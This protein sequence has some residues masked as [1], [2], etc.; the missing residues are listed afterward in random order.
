MASIPDQVQHDLNIIDLKFYDFFMSKSK[1]V[2]KESGRVKYGSLPKPW[3]KIFDLT[4]EYTEALWRVNQYTAFPAEKNVL[5]ER[6]RGAL[7]ELEI[8]YELR[9]EDPRYRVRWDDG[10]NC[11]FDWATSIRRGDQYLFKFVVDQICE[12]VTYIE[13]AEEELQEKAEEIKTKKY[14][15]LF[16]TRAKA[17]GLHIRLQMLKVAKN[18]YTVFKCDEKG[19]LSTFGSTFDEWNSFEELK[20]HV[21]YNE[22]CER[23]EGMAVDYRSIVGLYNRMQEMKK[24]VETYDLKRR[25]KKFPE[26]L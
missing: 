22:W 13:E 10:Y 17:V 4:M 23:T 9:E 6:V 1:W 7:P 16:R 8:A 12:T 21:C 19:D 24:W 2:D 11:T 26:L 25:T 15:E 3:Q 14:R 5:R 18:Y 20:E